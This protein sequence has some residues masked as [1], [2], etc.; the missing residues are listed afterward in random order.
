M[1][2]KIYDFRT[3][4]VIPINQT[5]AML[6]SRNKTALQPT[7]VKQPLKST[8][9]VKQI[10]PLPQKPSE[11]KIEYN[12]EA[13][14]KFFND[15]LI[16]SIEHP[17][18]ERPIVINHGGIITPSSIILSDAEAKN[19]MDEISSL[20]RI[21]IQKGVFKAMFDNLIITAVISEFIGIRFVIQRRIFR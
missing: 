17:G 4:K 6:K 13:I 10:K 1:H 16:L 3:I 19:I 21:P 9:P 14:K 5:S 20:T 8:K 11:L 7:I 15:P 2:K 12:L 18:Q